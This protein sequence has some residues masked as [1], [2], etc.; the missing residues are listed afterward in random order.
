MG[1][2]GDDV[3][4]GVDVDPQT[5]LAESFSTVVDVNVDQTSPSSFTTGG[6]TEFAL[7]NPVVALQS[8]GTADSPNLVLYLDLTGMDNITVSYL[9]RDID[10]SADNAVQ[11]VAAQFRIGTTGNFTNIPAAFVADASSGPSLATLTTPV[12]F[13]LPAAV[14]NQSQVQLRIL[15]TNST[16]SDEWIGVD[17]ISVSSIVPVPEPSA[18]LSLIGGVGMLC[19]LRRRV[20]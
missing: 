19:L 11:P 3:S 2:R 14:N 8:S 20:R 10:G 16:G 6:V 9:L 1:Y 5:V 17:D 7:A 12:S 18:F 15:L 4:Q 13:M